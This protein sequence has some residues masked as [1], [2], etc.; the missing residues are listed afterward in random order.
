LRATLPPLGRLALE[1]L[2]MRGELRP[3]FGGGGGRRSP[4][5]VRALV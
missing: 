3:A 4:W 5:N 2:L 1:A